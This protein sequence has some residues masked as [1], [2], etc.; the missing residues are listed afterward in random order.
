MDNLL[1]CLIFIITGETDDEIVT[2]IGYRIWFRWVCIVNT[3][4]DENYI[5]K[6]PVTPVN[7]AF[8]GTKVL[9]HGIFTEQDIADMPEHSS[10]NS[11]YKISFKT[12]L[13]IIIK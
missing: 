8:N 12:M 11:R 10:I 1:D 7:T 4:A 13:K 6:S 5:T 2:C 3:K 9:E